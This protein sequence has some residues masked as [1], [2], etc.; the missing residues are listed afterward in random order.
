MMKAIKTNHQNKKTN[1]KTF[2]FQFSIMYLISASQ[3]DGNVA[4][5]KIPEHE[6]E[7]NADNKEPPPSST[8]E[9]KNDDAEEKKTD[10]SEKKKDAGEEKTDQGDKK[11][12]EGEKTNWM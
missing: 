11:K 5:F 3:G 7:D 2:L 10:Q 8:N 4:S 12:N 6:F 9:K 1:V